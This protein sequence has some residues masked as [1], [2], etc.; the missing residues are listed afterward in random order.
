[1]FE[2]KGEKCE[3][4]HIQW[5]T[6]FNL[7]DIPVLR[8]GMARGKSTLPYADGEEFDLGSLIKD[9]E[10]VSSSNSEI[11]MSEHDLDE[12]KREWSVEF[13]HYMETPPL[14]GDILCAAG[15]DVNARLTVELKDG[16]P[17]FIYGRA[18]VPEIVGH[19]LGWFLQDT[20]TPN[21]YGWKCILLP[22]ARTDIVRKLGIQNDLLEVK[23]LVVVRYSRSKKA[24]LCEVHEYAEEIDTEEYQGPTP[25]D[26]P[27]TE[28]YTGPAPF[29]ESD[30]EEYTG[31]IPVT[32][33]LPSEPPKTETANLELKIETR[34]E[35]AHA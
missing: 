30:I 24:I 7:D 33:Q 21:F 14:P 13:D 16:K 26:E 19:V 27:D 3:N 34:D 17:P 5:Q 2:W 31:P 6:C 28:E 20:E 1:M 22:R 12:G 4:F 18:Y 10:S 23:S 29:D 25:F 9:G 8:P 11:V 32:G 15:T 35:T